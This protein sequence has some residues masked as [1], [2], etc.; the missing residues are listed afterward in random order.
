M[1]VCRESVCVSR[2]VVCSVCEGTMCS[3]WGVCV[4][5]MCVMC[6]VCVWNVCVWGVCSV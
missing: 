2:S 6:G 1:D 5:G 4:R 3:V